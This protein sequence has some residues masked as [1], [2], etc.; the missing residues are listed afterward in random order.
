MVRDFTI[1]EMKP[2]MNTKK[3]ENGKWK[4]G[5]RKFC[6]KTLLFFVY[7]FHFSIKKSVFI[8]LY[9]WSIFLFSCASKPT[10]LRTLAP[11]ETLAYLETNDL[12]KTLNSLTAS[13][14]FQEIASDKIDFSAVENIQIAI[15][16]T[17]FETSEKQITNE[18]S[19]LNFKPLFVAIAETHAWQWQAVSLVENQLNDF[20]KNSYGEDVKFEKSDK[21]GGKW[22]VWTAKEERKSF[23]FVRDSQ[24]FFGNDATA[25]EKCLAAKRNEADNLTKS[26]SFVRAYAA[27]NENLIVFGYVSPEGIAQIAN[28]AGISTAIEA[29][30]ENAGRSFIAQV[31]PQIVRNT[32]KEIVWTAT[33]S[34]QGIED[35]FS[36]SLNAEAISVFKETLIPNSQIRT[37]SPEFLPPGIFTSTGYNLKNPFIAW[38]SLLFVAAKNIDNFNGKNLVEFS[39][40]LLESYGFTDAET[41]LNSVDSD[42]LT[43]QFDADGEKSVTIVTVKDAEKL[44]KSIS[45]EINFK[46]LPEKQENADV[47]QS[48]DK[49]IAAA[50][51]ENK[52]LLG[53]TESVLKCLQ[54]K[55]SGQNSTKNQVFQK[56]RE[57]KLIAAT[58]AKDT[59][60]A[61]KV[62]K[63]LGDTRENKSA[64]T[65]YTT[66]TD[67]TEKGIQRK[68][69][70]AFGLLG[71][72]LEQLE[73]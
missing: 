68:T 27:N 8:C 42:I 5:N 67:F 2:Q 65:T 30:E 6:L 62:V 10:D 60:S 47:W 28:V 19:T 35:N 36:I 48:E 49:Q 70:S 23:A 40:N 34:E 4:I 11:A 72:I 61:A 58:F 13:K 55:Q 39:N 16:V 43:A 32:I 7:Q 45:D 64:V 46:T 26:E 57:S 20:V 52:L 50:F 66:E 29:T 53:E 56:F 14:A 54:A 73:E 1:K 12:A 37:N 22:F 69:I 21:N 71:T 44:K 38:R 18:N 33:K 25:I 31:L 24:I 59:D 63:V 3:N 17:G 9:L 15:A 41:F 51:V